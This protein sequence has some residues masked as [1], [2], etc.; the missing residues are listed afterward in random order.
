MI[1]KERSFGAEPQENNL[2]RGIY[3][4]ALREA[5]FALAQG[6]PDKLK[7]PPPKEATIRARRGRGRG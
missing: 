6:K 7:F 1:A 5:P 2:V 4:G 3:V